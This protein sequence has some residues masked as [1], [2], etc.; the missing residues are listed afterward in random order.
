MPD[1]VPNPAPSPVPDTDAQTAENTLRLLPRLALLPALLC[2]TA[3]GGETLWENGGEYVKTAPHGGRANDHPFK[4]DPELLGKA[5]TRLRVEPA[6]KQSRD[7]LGEDDEDRAALPLFTPATARRLARYVAE[8]L[9]SVGPDEDVVFRSVDT[10]PLFGKIIGKQVFVSARVFWRDRR[11]NVIFGK[12]HKNVKKRWLYGHEKGY[13]NPPEPGNRGKAAA[14]KLR[15]VEMPGV[16]NVRTL[17]GRKR[18]DW[19]VIEPRTLAE[20]ETDAVSRPGGSAKRRP[21]LNGSPKARLRR[22][23]ELR[24]EGLISEQEYRRKRARILEEL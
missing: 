21:A 9:R 23:K 13:V 19:I 22:L 12:I 20:A 1:P 14:L 16:S 18:I 11:L 7:V 6:K 17:D 10:A 15:V 4:I 8:G 2:A 5:M 3:A 24:D